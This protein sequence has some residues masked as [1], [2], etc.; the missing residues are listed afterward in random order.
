MWI[1]QATQSQIRGWGNYYRHSVAKQTYGYVDCQIFKTLQRWAKRRHPSKGARWVIRKY[2][3]PEYAR[4]W[5]FQGEVT[6]WWCDDLSI[7]DS[8]GHYLDKT[9][10]QN[11]LRGNTLLSGVRQLMAITQGKS[12]QNW[13]SWHVSPE[14]A[15]WEV[16]PGNNECLW[17][18]WAECGES[19]ML[20]S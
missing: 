7:S 20:R 3:L 6:Y 15:L 1:N 17:G 2:F 8:T 19:R 14:A 9:A 10:Y 16:L 5:Y 18:A 11:L 4:H 13:I 12:G